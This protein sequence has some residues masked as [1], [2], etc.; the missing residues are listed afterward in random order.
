MPRISLHLGFYRL[1]FAT[2]SFF[3]KTLLM[4]ISKTVARDFLRVVELTRQPHGSFRFACAKAF[5]L[6]GAAIYNGKGIAVPWTAV[7]CFFRCH[8]QM[9]QVWRSEISRF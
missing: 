9:P 6:V 7:E 4:L 2:C 5:R 1:L 3:G 8:F